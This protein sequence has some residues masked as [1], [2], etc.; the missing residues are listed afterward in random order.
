MAAGAE[1]DSNLP[2]SHIGREQVLDALKAAF[3]H[4]RLAKEEFD[5]RVGQVLVAY[6][7]LDAVTADIPAGL[8]K[9]LPP[10][11]IQKPHNKKL[12]R[13][14]AAAGAGASVALTATIAVAAREI[15]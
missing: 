2:T 4:G 1:D 12:I 9:A 8:T 3:V 15:L 11:T 5:L 6:A 13:R 7:E 14:G 10:Q